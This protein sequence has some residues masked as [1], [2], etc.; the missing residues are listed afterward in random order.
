MQGVGHFLVGGRPRQTSRLHI[1][2]IREDGSRSEISLCGKGQGARGWQEPDGRILRDLCLDCI[3]IFGGVKR[4]WRM[5]SRI[6]Q[7]Y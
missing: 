6:R 7:T 5:N 2:R 1:V 4:R 3:R